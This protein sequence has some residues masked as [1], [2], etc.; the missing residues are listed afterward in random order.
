M[1]NNAIATGLQ[2]RK[3]SYSGDQGGECLECA[4]TGTLAWRKA[5]YSGDTGG[6][7]VEIAETPHATVAVRDS[8]NPAGPALA[9]GPAAFTGFVAWAATAAG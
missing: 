3:S 5:S 2:W 1:A 7:C 6:S 9:F 4:P 8:K